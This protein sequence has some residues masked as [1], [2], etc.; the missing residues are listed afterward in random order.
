MVLH[1]TSSDDSPRIDP[2]MAA[3]QFF[4]EVYE[5]QFDDLQDVTDIHQITVEMGLTSWATGGTLV[6]TDAGRAAIEAA[7]R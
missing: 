1:L 2:L 7:K 4:S 5:T 6:L 3:C